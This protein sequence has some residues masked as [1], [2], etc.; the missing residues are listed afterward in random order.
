VLVG[1]E[2]L[3]FLARVAKPMTLT[4]KKE[5]RKTIVELCKK[6]KVCPYCR[7]VQT[8]I[9]RFGYYRM[10]MDVLRPQ[11][12]Q[13]KLLPYLVH[14]A[15]ETTSDN[16]GDFQRVDLGT[17]KV[18]AKF[19]FCRMVNRLTELKAVVQIYSLPRLSDFNKIFSINSK[20]RLKIPQ[21]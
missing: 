19:L 17:A 12:T 13:R 21:P 20:Q 11:P 5:L 15:E 6:Q 2:R 18:C 7:T 9:R 8:N 3:S 1:P 14:M 10:V 4:V 16:A